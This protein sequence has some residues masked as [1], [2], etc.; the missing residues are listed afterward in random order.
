[1]RRRLVLLAVAAA[2]FSTSGASAALVRVQQPHTGEV[3]QPRLRAGHITIPRGQRTGRVRVITTLRMPP[4]AAA[5]GSTFALAGPSRHLDVKSASS[6]AYLAAIEQAQARAASQL[7][8]AIPSARVQQRYRI[9]LDGFAVSVPATKLPALRKLAYVH[10]IYPSMQYTQNLNRSPGVIGASQYEAATGMRGDG[11][12]IGIVDDGIDAANRF[13]NPTGYQYPLGFPKGGLK[14]TTPKVIVARAYPGPGSGRAGRLPVDPR[15]SFHATHVAGIAA[16]IAGTTA[17]AGRDHPITTGLSGVAPRAYLGNYRVFNAPTPIGNI[18]NT[19]E[20]VK[21]FEDAV[22][23]GM[24][25]INFSGGGPQTDPIND[26]MYETVANVVNAGVV[27]VISAGN[28]RED[29]GLGTAGSPGTV[30][31]AISVAAVSNS[32]VF[33]PAL[34]VSAPGAPAA[35]ARLPFIPA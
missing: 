16:G 18:A 23:D 3:V 17:P 10:R 9:L 13:F 5:R 12:K 35:V 32:Q 4:L 25:V 2:L 26:A 14:W 1:M 20:I 7:K 30:P 8:A 22:A 33:A 24:D 19:P 15:A 6:A 28:D 29:F 34:T 31:D 11:I 27:P 21:A